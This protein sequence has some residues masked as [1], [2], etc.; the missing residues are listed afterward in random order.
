[1]YVQRL[2]VRQHLLIIVRADFEGVLLSFSGAF[3]TISSVDLCAIGGFDLGVNVGGV[4]AR[5]ARRH[6]FGYLGGDHQCLV[7]VHGGRRR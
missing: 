6:S 3:G 4:E 5:F 7:T 1:M 2:F